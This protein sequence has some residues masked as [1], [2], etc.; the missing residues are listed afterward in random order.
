MPREPAPIPGTELF[1][2]LIS[3]NLL[4]NYSKD[5]G[6]GEV[7][8]QGQLHWVSPEFQRL[9]GLCKTNKYLRSRQGNNIKPLG[10]IVIACEHH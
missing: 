2:I 5:E 3:L 4:T 10:R 7:S 6:I 8:V 9:Y 1:S